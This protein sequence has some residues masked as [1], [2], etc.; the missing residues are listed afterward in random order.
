MM[1][2]QMQKMIQTV[3]T[4]SGR[5][6]RARLPFPL[7]TILVIAF[8]FLFPFS[9]LQAAHAEAPD[10]VIITGDTDYPPSSWG[11][12]N[13]LAGAAID[14][15]KLAF[16]ELD[17]PIKVVNK[18]P[19]KRAQEA[20]KYGEADIITSVYR[21]PERQSYA[22]YTDTPYMIERNVIWVMKDKVFPFDDWRDLQD[23]KAGLLLGNSYGAEWDTLFER[24]LATEEVHDMHSNL[25]KLKSGRIDY[26]PYALYPGTIL[27][28][29]YGY[30]DMVECLPTTMA[31]VGVYIAFSKKSEFLH[32]L[33]AIN[34][35]IA[36]YKADGTM[37]RL[38][39]GNID[40]YL[41]GHPK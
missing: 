16:A 32:L 37:Q 38:I 20:L 11:D 3:T 35:A 36:R 4:T 10:P 34:K 18:G 1:P 8:L 28:R 12:G 25:K 2:G 14:A 39:E 19:W 23:K 6:V 40:D 13:T 17:I 30:Q 22:V 24:V 15:L 26:I 7:R 9:G 5:T 41:L 33:P 21:T 29:R 27:I 31:S